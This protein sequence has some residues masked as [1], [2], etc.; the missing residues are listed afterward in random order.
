MTP[1]SRVALI[2]AAVLAA[3]G[4]A[5]LATGL[6]LTASPRSAA[7]EPSVPCTV[8]LTGPAPDVEF[9]GV[10]AYRA[11][12]DGETWRF[13]AGT[14]VPVCQGPHDVGDLV[15]NTPDGHESL[16]VQTG[17]QVAGTALISY[18]LSDTYYT[19]VVAIPD[20]DELLL[21]ATSIELGSDET[22]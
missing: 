14:F 12:A 3:A 8:A 17:S 2:G 5:A 11:H 13:G 9:P 19:T 22:D 15:I 6:S 4:A 16:G 7:P 21:T 18:Y 20:T 10:L 1:A